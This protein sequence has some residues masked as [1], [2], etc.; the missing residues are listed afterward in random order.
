MRSL[1]S[2]I[3]ILLMFELSAQ[4]APEHSNWESITSYPNGGRDDGSGFAIDGML[5]FGCG[6]NASFQLTNDWSAFDTRTNSWITMDTLP[7]E[8]R[9]YACAFASNSRGFLVGGIKDGSQFTNA[10]FL[11]I[12]EIM[13]WMKLNNAPWSA[14][15]AAAVFVVGEYAYL[16]G[17]RN[18]S[19]HFNDLWRFN[20][21]TLSWDSL[22]TIPGNGKDEM[23]AFS[24]H[25]SGYF[26]LGREKSG[27]TTNE[28]WRFDPFNELWFKMSDFPGSARA[29]A[30]G[31]S[32]RSG[33]LIV[34]GQSDSLDLLS[35]VYYY[36]SND[37][38]WTIIADLPQEYRG[39]E[40][41]KSGNYY[42]TFG[43]L[44]H[45]FTRLDAVYRLEMLESKM[46][47]IPRPFNVSPNPSNSYVVIR[48]AFDQPFVSVQLYGISGHLILNQPSISSNF[49]TTINVSEVPPG[50]YILNIEGK[51][52]TQQTKLAIY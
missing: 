52:V 37:D 35:E 50:V 47:D 12:P 31:S 14:R 39:A 9:Q 38:R 16:G 45:R 43:G 33:A 41:L 8:A 25:G 7:A 32:A 26:M 4:I 17:G 19:V 40:L 49:H 22:G 30:A 36:D 42:Y 34:G 5:F 23:V 1:F 13:Q 28:V 2:F 46:Q 11:F 6:M 29:Y 24:A 10:C 3:L 18:D 21:T 51:N 48:S 44:T 20:M 15:G 27:E